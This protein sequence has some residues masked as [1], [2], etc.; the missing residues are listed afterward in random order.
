MIPKC[1]IVVRAYNEAAHISKLLSGIMAQTKKDFEIILV[2]S[3]STDQTKQIASQYPVKIVHISPEEFTF[4]RALNRGI[5]AAQGEFIVIISAHCYPVSQDW[6][7]Q[8]LSPFSDP[9]VAVSYGKQRGGETNQYSEHQWFR[10]YFPELTILDQA[11]PYCHNANGAIRRSLWQ[12]QPYDEGLTGLEDLAWGSW[13]MEAGYKIAYQGEAGVIHL[14]N[15]DPAQVYNRYRRE[16][17]AMRQILPNSKFGLTQLISLYL[18]KVFSDSRQALR[19]KV[20][21]KQL[22]SIKWFRLM[23]YLGT[24]QG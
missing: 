10:Q 18:R 15:E 13:V 8:L 23:Q 14:H 6:L 1:S 12:Q 11:H 20:F 4:G 5:Q 21:L 3:G 19:E 17:I 22:I 24:W 2:D 9:E 16:S 7:S